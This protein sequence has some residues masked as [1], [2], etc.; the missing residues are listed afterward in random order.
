MVV[1]SV[2]DDNITLHHGKPHVIAASIGM[3][4]HTV[5]E[6]IPS[7]QIQVEYCCHCAHKLNMCVQ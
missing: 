6:E 2:D 3:Q 5:T 7:Q 4:E 1:E